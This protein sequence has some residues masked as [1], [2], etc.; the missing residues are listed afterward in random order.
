MEEGTDH[1][2]DTFSFEI[3]V[4]FLKKNLIWNKEK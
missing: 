3:T 4:F 1:T 2:S